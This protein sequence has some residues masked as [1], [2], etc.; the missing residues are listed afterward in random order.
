MNRGGDFSTI[1]KRDHF[2]ESVEERRDFCQEIA[3]DGLLPTSTGRALNGVICLSSIVPQL[4][5]I[6]HSMKK[7]STLISVVLVCATTAFAAH[8]SPAGKVV[9]IGP[10][11]ITLH[12]VAN[13][14]NEP[15]RRTARMGSTSEQTYTLTPQTTYWQGGKQIGLSNIQKGVTATVTSAHGVASRIDIQ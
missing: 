12:W 2:V 15:M 11:T 10:N 5:Q 1:Y 7:L 4:I 9:K 13:T 6:M 8:T 3:I 14:R